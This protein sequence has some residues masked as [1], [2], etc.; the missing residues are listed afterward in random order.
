MR[1]EDGTD[2]QEHQL[3]TRLQN[4]RQMLRRTKIIRKEM[5]EKIRI[6]YAQP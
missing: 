6:R 4:V 3:P 1:V 5:I 2:K